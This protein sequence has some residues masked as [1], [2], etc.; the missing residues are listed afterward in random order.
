MS[1]SEVAHIFTS[2]VKVPNYAHR[3]RDIAD[4]VEEA[5]RVHRFSGQVLSS[6]VRVVVVGYNCFA[7]L[8]SLCLFVACAHLCYSLSIYRSLSFSGVLCLCSLS[9]FS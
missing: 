4:L 3:D 8:A 6:N 9:L 1:L 2:F 7:L 5:R